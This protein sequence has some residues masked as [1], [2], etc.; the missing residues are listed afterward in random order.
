MSLLRFYIISPFFTIK[1]ASPLFPRKLTEEVFN[2]KE[3]I[4]IMVSGSY[5]SLEWVPIILLYILS[6][7]FNK[8]S[9]PPGFFKNYIE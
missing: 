9:H 1:E 3:P 5:A 7:S 8:L 4:P 6:Q 2:G